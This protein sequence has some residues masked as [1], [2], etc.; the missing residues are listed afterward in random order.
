MYNYR[1]KKLAIETAQLDADFFRTL[2]ISV[3]G[4]FLLPNLRILSWTVE[5]DGF[6]LFCRIFLPPTVI[7]V[8]VVLQDCTPD[9][10][11]F[12]T[13]GV[14][15][16]HLADIHVDVPASSSSVRVVSNTLCA[17]KFLKKL[18]VVTLDEIALVH[19]AGLPQLEDLQ[20]QSY[21]PPLNSERLSRLIPVPA[22]PALRLLEIIGD[23]IESAFSLVAHISSVQFDELH[24]NTSQCT[25]S[26]AWKEAFI[27][28]EHL[29]SRQNLSS[30]SLW[31]RDNR[32]PVPVSMADK[33]ILDPETIAPLLN[34]GNLVNLSLQPFF[35][36]DL[37]DPM[38][39]RMAVA[40]PFLETLELGA[41]R[42]APR[43]PRATLRSLVYLAEHCP[44]LHSLQ[45]AIDATDPVPRFTRPRKTHPRH[46]LGY[47]HTGP[48]PITSPAAVAAFLS[49][50]F[51]AIRFGHRG[52]ND[53]ERPWNEVS[54]LFRVFRS[55]RAA[56]AR[57]WTAE[58]PDSDGW[59]SGNET[60][61]EEGSDDGSVLYLFL[62]I[63]QAFIPRHTGRTCS[64]IASVFIIIE[65]TENWS[66]TARTKPGELF[67]R[68]Y[69]RR[70]L[71]AR[72]VDIPSST[73]SLH[74]CFHFFHN[75]DNKLNHRPLN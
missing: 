9:L 32:P 41:E 48:S 43:P 71:K 45:L 7:S 37:D 21:I 29:P 67:S 61:D 57:C 14:S 46:R 19:I 3:P 42:A 8:S 47:F 5:D 36:L 53:T 1:V 39:H 65:H 66:Q 70:S 31:Q 44:N 38:V 59:S 56:E 50:S 40:W 30:I 55:V 12:S 16:P 17:W 11:L 52:D 64:C 33:Y 6:F 26:Y 22:F 54:R 18:T 58:Y 2:E 20:L 60:S 69:G 34:F 23:T 51:A 24:I 10:S 72:S 63:T 74:Q 35:G 28:L 13:L 75:R 15:H 62:D 73:S 4:S 27:T 49:N 68:E 25:S